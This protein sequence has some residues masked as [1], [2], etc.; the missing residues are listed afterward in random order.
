MRHSNEV[1]VVAG[2]S[3]VLLLVTAIVAGQLSHRFSDRPRALVAIPSLL[4]RR[5]CT[6]QSRARGSRGA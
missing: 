2:A 5:S 6:A 3:E 1:V 4:H